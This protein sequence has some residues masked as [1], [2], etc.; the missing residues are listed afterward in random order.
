ML[1]GYANG[2][3]QA[4]G[5]YIGALAAV[6][7]HYPR[8]VA[9]QAGDLIKGVPRETR[10]LPTPADVIGWCERETEYLRSIV[11]RDDREQRLRAEAEARRKADEKLAADRRLRPTLQQLHEQ[12]GPDWGIGAGDDLSRAASEK[13]RALAAEANDR[14]RAAEYAAAG[15]EPRYAAPGIPISLPLL[16]LLRSA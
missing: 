4:S 8:C 12:Y 14:L 2:G 1:R 15:L 13:T 6:L 5:S 10:F 11:E 3:Q 16:K 7:S 9:S